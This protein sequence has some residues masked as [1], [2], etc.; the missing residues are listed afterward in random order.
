[1]KSSWKILEFLPK[2]GETAKEMKD[3]VLK[4]KKKREKIENCRVQSYNNASN[5]NGSI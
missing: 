1:M 5:M 2:A 4:I 3:T